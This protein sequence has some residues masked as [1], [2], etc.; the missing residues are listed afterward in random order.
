MVW[1][2]IGVI[3]ASLFGGLIGAVIALNNSEIDLEVLF[4]ILLS[5][6]FFVILCIDSGINDIE[7][8]A[9]L[10]GVREYVENPQKYKVTRI[11]SRLEINFNDSIK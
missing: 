5:A 6:I 9:R 7:K 2:V 8:D 3:L 4:W 10:E 11:P 1:I